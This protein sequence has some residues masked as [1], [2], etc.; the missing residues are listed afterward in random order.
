MVSC[1]NIP[2]KQILSLTNLLEFYSTRY[3][4]VIVLGDFNVEAENK[5]MKD[6]LQE[7]TFYKMMK[8]N[9][10]FKGDRGSC[11][12]L[13]I[14]N[15]K[16]SFLKKNSFETGLRDHHHMIYTIL[17]TKF[18]KFEPKKL[19]YRNFKQFDSVQFKLD[20]CNNMSAVRTHAAFE[21]NFVSILDKHAPKKTKILRGNKNPF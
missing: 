12:D 4:K 17:K 19:I 20:I 5:V 1:I 16:F 18:E 15:S 13:L 2:G 7:H 9:T 14:T 3:E 6:F 10:C 11:I 8:H 21:G